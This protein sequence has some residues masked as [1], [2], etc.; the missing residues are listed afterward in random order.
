MSN[1]K[2]NTSFNLNV[3][4]PLLINPIMKSF[5][6]CCFAFVIKAISTNELND[7]N[8]I[9]ILPFI[10]KNKHDACVC[11]FLCDSNECWFWMQRNVEYRYALNTYSIETNTTLYLSLTM[12]ILNNGLLNWLPFEIISRPYVIHRLKYV[13]LKT[14]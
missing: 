1:A 12:E 14:R 4:Q 11:V 2:D 13:Q 5:S 3:P 7:F 9:V 10:S 8:Y 6:R